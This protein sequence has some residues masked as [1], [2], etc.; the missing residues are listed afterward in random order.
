M[1]KHTKNKVRPIQEIEMQEQLQRNTVIEKKLSQ[2]Q[3]AL[4]A[5]LRNILK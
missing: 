1:E 3:N 5:L 2:T 4:F